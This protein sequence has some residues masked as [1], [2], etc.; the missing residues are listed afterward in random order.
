MKENYN[1]YGELL[2]MVR[3]GKSYG[4]DE[5]SDGICSLATMS[6]IENGERSV[7]FIMVEAI[8]DRMKIS[9]DE[10]EFIL[11]DDEYEE[12][13]NRE[14]I[15]TLIDNKKYAEA[16]Q[17]LISYEKKYKGQPLHQQFIYMQ[18]A[19]VEQGLRSENTENIKK[20]YESALII[21]APNYQEKYKKKAVLSERELVCLIEMQRYV[22]DSVEREQ[23]FFELYDYYNS[24]KIRDNY[25]PVSYR[26]SMQY[27]AES[28]LENG[29]CELCRQICDEVLEELYLTGRAANRD[30]IFLLRAKCREQA[31]F[32]GEEEKELCLKDYLTAY[33]L[34]EF[35]EGEE[36][37][38]ALREYIGGTF[39]W[40][41]IV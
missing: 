41:Y 26:I 5:V 17:L 23:K 7:E 12:Y 4:L 34:M 22:A 31:G 3:E 36:K 32:S 11:E 40:Q 19:R 13:Q 20:W 6:R 39:G 24:C 10:F 35:Y 18:K 29:K 37:T 8:L 14:Q 30:E 15:K 1:D 28:L 38:K 2:K 16:E 9:T 27:Y 33:Y 25:F 21:T